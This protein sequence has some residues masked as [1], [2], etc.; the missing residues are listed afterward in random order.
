MDRERLLTRAR[1]IGRFV[2]LSIPPLVAAVFVPARDGQVIPWRADTVDMMVYR[3]TAEVLLQGHNFYDPALGLPFIYP[4]FAAIAAIP[5]AI[6]D[7]SL[8][9][10]LWALVNGA[11]VVAIV[12]RFGLHDWRLSFVATAGI[13]LCRPVESTL[14]LGQINIVIVAL[15][16]FD[17]V[18][19]PHVVTERRLWPRGILIGI[20]TA[21]KLTPAVFAVYLFLAGRRKPAYLAFAS[22]CLCTAIGWLVLPGASVQFWLGLLHGGGSGV[23]NGV[24]YYTNQSVIATYVRWFGRYPDEVSAPAVVL[25]LLVV[26]LGLV[27]AS[28]WHRRGEPALALC[29][30]GLGSLL[31]S[32]IAWEHHFVWALPLALVLFRRDTLPGVLRYVGLLL[33]A[34]L[35]WGPWTRLPGN[36]YAELY[37]PVW[38]KLVDSG[39]ALLGVVFLVTALIAGIRLRRADGFA[40]LPLTLRRSENAK[41][42]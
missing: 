26:A 36:G 31:G 35:W 25:A 18:P 11:L 9:Q 29:I 22:F 33:C 16:V 24:V 37:F 1:R 28:I 19:G 27:A 30:C 39:S 12:R 7:L 13:W 10:V 15:V 2:A 4:P 21:I 41:A 34:W 8:V 6:P 32:P 40:A 20:A 42:R 5:F 17:L 38:Q 14:F 3:R 23:A